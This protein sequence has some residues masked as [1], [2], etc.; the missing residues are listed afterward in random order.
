MLPPWAP[1]YC[2]AASKVGRVS[3]AACNNR[4]AITGTWAR[5]NAWRSW[6]RVTITG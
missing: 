1:S 3:R 4:E 5:P 6:G 2:G